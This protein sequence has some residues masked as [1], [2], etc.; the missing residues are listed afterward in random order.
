MKLT[1]KQIYDRLCED[2]KGLTDLKKK[3]SIIGY[4]YNIRSLAKDVGAESRYPKEVILIT[5]DTGTGKTHITKALANILD[6]P[7][8]YISCSGVSPVGYVGPSVTQR[9]FEKLSLNPGPDNAP[10][11]IIFIDEIDKLTF[12]TNS[13]NFKSGEIIQQEL[14]TLLEGMIITD[15][16]GKG[17]V[18]IKT[19]NC[20]FIL[21]GSFAH[22]KE[23]K[24]NT[25]RGIGFK[26][27]EPDTSKYEVD[28]NK[29]GFIPELSGRITAVG[30]TEPLTDKLIKEVILNTPTG[31]YNSYKRLFEVSGQALKLTNKEV[32]HIVDVVKNS[33]YGMREI[34][35]IM[36][37]LLEKKLFNLAV[38]SDE[39]YDNIIEELIDSRR[40]ERDDAID[41]TSEILGYDYIG[42]YGDG[43]ELIKVTF[44]TSKSLIIKDEEEEEDGDEDE[45]EDDKD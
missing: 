43:N 16:R 32:K 21:A 30:K 31:S 42:E 24:K 45:D 19:D 7:F 1:P 4:N 5:G 37:K 39:I 40:Q 36:F 34:N 9:M 22:C 8:C 2:V 13:N 17:D 29:L 33:E 26:A 38:E 10:S 12:N 15:D 18:K 11:A 6:Y 35:K 20:L 3:L 25:P 27:E 44:S 23:E 14:L 41:L 28:P